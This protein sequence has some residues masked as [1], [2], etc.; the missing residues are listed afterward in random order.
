M[1]S[2]EM[3]K[4]LDRLSVDTT[5]DETVPDIWLLAPKDQDRVHELFAKLGDPEGRDQTITPDEEQELCGMLDGL[6]VLGPDDR[7]AGPD[8]EVPKELQFYWTWSQPA[9]GWR[10]YDFHRLKCVQKVRFAELCAQYGYK[11]GMSNVEVKQNLAHLSQWLKD[12]QL[13]M[14]GLLQ[15][16]SNRPDFAAVIRRMLHAAA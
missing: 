4:K 5:E 3:L 10:P 6:P 7:S 2:R 11:K 9:D 16:A 14:I 12:D 8:L 15:A 13:A 1:R